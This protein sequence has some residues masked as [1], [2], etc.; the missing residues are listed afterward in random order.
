M[1][2]RLPATDRPLRRAVCLLTAVAPLLLCPPTKGQSFYQVSNPRTY[3]IDPPITPPL[4]DDLVPQM[5]AYRSTG[6]HGTGSIILNWQ[7]SQGE[8]AA[9]LEVAVDL[10][11]TPPAASTNDATLITQIPAFNVATA[12][13]WQTDQRVLLMSRTVGQR[14]SLI[15]LGPF[16]FDQ[17]GNITNL[18]VDAS[19]APPVVTGGLGTNLGPQGLAF[20]GVRDVGG[21]YTT[22]A[23]IFAGDPAGLWAADLTTLQW[24]DASASNT[25]GANPISPLVP[26]SGNT[27]AANLDPGGHRLRGV[28]VLGDIA[29]LLTARQSD[30]ADA[31]SI[32][33]YLIQVDL[34]VQQ[35]LAVVNLGDLFDSRIT[36]PT[37]ALG[38]DVDV[39]ATSSSTVRILFNTPGSGKYIG[40]LDGKLV[41]NGS[42]A[43]AP[44]SGGGD[45][46]SGGETPSTDGQA[47]IWVCPGFGI[48]LPLLF[49]LAG[50]H[51]WYAQRRGRRA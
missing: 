21:V 14:Q 39:L 38:G 8:A 51:A 42:P 24:L 33:Y 28:D 34:R 44:G 6:A 13:D 26:W 46:G 17:Q 40:A 19:I 50:A 49:S 5:L 48:A 22:A 12:M 23:V 11:A 35:R 9:T 16:V 27:G 15:A 32:Q 30:P 31:G 1:T 47:V 25:G 29:F 2:P 37:D 20:S 7:T 4:P 3:R 41:P 45:G 43:I 18:R 36:S 10:T